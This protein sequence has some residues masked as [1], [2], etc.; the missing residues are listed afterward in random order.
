MN[1]TADEVIL[2]VPHCVAQQIPGNGLD[3]VFHELRAVA[4]QTLPFLRRTD[5]LIGY[6]QAAKSVEKFT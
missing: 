1:M 3:D 5:A 6:G 2:Q 4:F